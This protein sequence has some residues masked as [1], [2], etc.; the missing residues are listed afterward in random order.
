[1]PGLGVAIDDQNVAGVAP[2]MKA[3]VGVQAAEAGLMLGR[4]DRSQVGN[5][6]DKNGS[7][8]RVSAGK[9]SCNR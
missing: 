3:A 7:K 9:P 5:E 8:I 4:H 1:V 6:D 2:G